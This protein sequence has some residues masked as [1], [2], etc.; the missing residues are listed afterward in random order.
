MQAFNTYFQY[1]CL[2]LNSYNI[3]INFMREVF[4]MSSNMYMDLLKNT[5]NL[6]TIGELTLETGS[7][8]DGRKIYNNNSY[9]GKYFQY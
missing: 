8:K 4:S 6:S 5:I 3:I 1:V 7:A 2:V 9:K